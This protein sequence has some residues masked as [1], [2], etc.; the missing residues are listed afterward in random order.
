MPAAIRDHIEQD[1]LRQTLAHRE[2]IRSNFPRTD[3]AAIRMLTVID[4]D[5]NRAEIDALLHEL[6]TRGTAVDGV[7]GEK[8]LNG[9]AAWTSSG[10]F[11]FVAHLAITDPARCRELLS[12][13]PR[14]HAGV[15][16]FLDTWC[17]QKYYPSCGDAGAFTQ[18]QDG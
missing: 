9:Y 1:L 16:F 5:A 2:R 18:P 3:L 4:A 15:R 14:I 10:I 8:G 13:Y 17:L 7:T 11:E 12:R 6:I